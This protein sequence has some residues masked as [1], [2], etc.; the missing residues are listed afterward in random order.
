MPFILA[1][2]ARI[3]PAV[4]GGQGITIPAPD[5]P[6]VIGGFQ[7]YL[8]LL[9]LAVA[10]GALLTAFLIEQT[11]TG[12]ALFAIHDAEDV[13]EGIGV[14]TFRAKMVAIGLSGLIGGLSGTLYAQ[15]IGFVTVEGVFGLTIPL[16]V[17]VM[18]VLGG[19]D[20][21]VGPLLGAVVIVTLQNRLSAAGS[22]AGA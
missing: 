11:R 21:W 14:P 19:R 13:A 8:Y 22:R 7:A 2:I 20:T 4:D 10:A 1:S 15:Q 9:S 16:F 18:S 6:E 3:V 17:I 12:W 5:V